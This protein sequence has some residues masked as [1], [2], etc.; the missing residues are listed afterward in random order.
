M[1]SRETRNSLGGVLVSV[2]LLM[3]GVGLL[4]S[5]VALRGEAEGFS[6]PTIGLLMSGYFAGYLTGST[7]TG[8]VVTRVGHIRAFAA[9]AAIASAAFLLHGLGV[10]PAVWLVLRIVSGFCVAALIVV[11][12][13]WLNGTSSNAVRGTVLA[14]Y[15]AAVFAGLALGQVLLNL[16]KPGAIGLFALVSIFVSIS[17]VPVALTRLAT[18]EVSTTEPMSLPTVYRASPGAFAA[19][20]TSGLTQS[21][22]LT[23]GALYATQAGLSRA[24]ASGFVAAVLVAAMVSAIPVGRLSD[25]MD[26]RR[27][28]AVLAFGTAGVCAP[29]LFLVDDAGAAAV[30]AT[31]AAV[32]ALTYPLY[33]L[34]LAELNDRLSPDEILAAG[35][36]LVLVYAL[37]GVAGPLVAS[38][39]MSSIGPEGFWWY[40]LVLHAALGG[41][42]LYRLTRLAPAETHSPYS[43]LPAATTPVVNELATDAAPTREQAEPT[44][45]VPQ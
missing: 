36:K 33:P 9:F 17:I 31:G 26:R 25:R 8:R 27:L 43:P 22:I 5:L 40:Q 13:S 23:L 2:A 18:P 20:A 10:H 30:I 19:A 6:T 28:L 7:W 12:E 45:Q 3:A 39:L 16:D 4:Q 11:V 38:G 14:L 44:S 24:Q 41:F 37:G 42:T 34:G 15:M 1:I 32:G 29:L 21:A 35:A